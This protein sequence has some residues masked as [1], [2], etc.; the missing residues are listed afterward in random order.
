VRLGH[1]VDVVRRESSGKA[2]IEL[3]DAAIASNR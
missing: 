3:D 2:I 1:G